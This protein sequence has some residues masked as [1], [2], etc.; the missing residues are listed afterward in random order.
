MMLDPKFDA[1]SEDP[2]EVISFHASRLKDTSDTDTD[3]GTIGQFPSSRIQQKIKARAAELKGRRVK[4]PNDQMDDLRSYAQGLMGDE[5]RDL[6]DIVK[7]MSDEHNVDASGLDQK[8]MELLGSHILK[9]LYDMDFKKAMKNYNNLRIRLMLYSN[10]YK[11]PAR[12][13]FGNLSSLVTEDLASIANDSYHIAIVGPNGSGKL[14]LAKALSTKIGYNFAVSDDF[15]ADL[16]PD[17][18]SYARKTPLHV[19]PTTRKEPKTAMYEMLDFVMEHKSPLIYVGSMVP[20]LL[21]AGLRDQMYVPDTVI[22]VECN[23]STL[24]HGHIVRNH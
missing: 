21:R 2:A 24:E 18:H 3:P 5:N 11:Q 8:R 6:A 4:L 23:Q 7:K 17:V 12:A 14:G 22:V 19:Q 15:I 16:A 1:G 20:R 13:T 9:N 10:R